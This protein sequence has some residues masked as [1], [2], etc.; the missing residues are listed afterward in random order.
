M[1]QAKQKDSRHYSVSIKVD[2]PPQDVYRSINNVRGWW[3]GDIEGES[4]KV[5]DEFIYRYKDFHITTQKLVELV[6]GQKIV[7]TVTQ[8]KINFVQNKD[9]W[10]DTQ[11]V[12]ELSVEGGGTRIN[13]THVG[14]TPAIE[15]YGGCSGGWDF[16]ILK[17]LQSFLQT[18][19]GIAP[20]F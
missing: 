17:S 9:E 7:W 13:F 20:N 4:D 5:G 3:I 18:G 10:K 2:Q 16:Y 1:S 12:F 6:P 8:S 11:I 14:L 15:C 19:K